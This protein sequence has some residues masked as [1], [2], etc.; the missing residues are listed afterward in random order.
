M[1][2]SKINV[3]ELRKLKG[4][5]CCNCGDECGDNIIFHHIIPIS[6]GGNDI[7]SNIVP[8]CTLCHNLLHGI[9]KDG[10]IS[11]SELTKRGI[12]RARAEGKQI[13]G[14]KGSTYNVKKKE[15]A[16]EI[17]KKYSITFGGPLN[18][19]ECMQMADIS[20]GTFYKYLRELKKD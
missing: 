19:L 2:Q 10:K 9:S 17:I 8:L 1:P 12:E 18:N 5:K 6:I 16:I 3:K 15:K 20:N 14:V 4:T 11:H 7:E 13:G